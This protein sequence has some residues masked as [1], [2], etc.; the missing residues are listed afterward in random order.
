MSKYHK[1]SKIF[2]TEVVIKVMDLNRAVEFYK[3]I[4]GFKVLRKKE[5][6]VVMTVDG[7]NPIVTLIRPDDIVPKEHRRTGLYHFAILLPTRKDLGKFIKN[8]R[9]KG[10]PIVGGSNHGVSEALYLQDPEDNGIEVY[11]DTP[12]RN[13]ERTLIGVKMI[14]E[15]MD[16]RGLI[17]LAGDDVW[18][19]APD[20][21][22]LG[23]MHLHVSNLDE[24]LNFYSAL[25]FK[26]VQAMMDQAYFVS[27][28]GYHHH[29]GFNI[30]N[31]KG[32]PPPPEDSAGMKY[33]TLKFPD[34]DTRKEK[35]NNLKEQGYVMIEKN[36]K[37]FTRDPSKNLIKLIV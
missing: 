6:K 24:S 36:N 16:Y 22:I 19:G 8:I 25:G 23:H 26:L 7:I 33:F 30:W 37:L 34:E 3:S 12:D 31:G 29:I 35:I 18:Q 14:T 27:T 32:A 4:M 13:W 28:G 9:E 15:P 10:Y 5:K 1:G 17:E 2:V 11:A 21:T 20:G